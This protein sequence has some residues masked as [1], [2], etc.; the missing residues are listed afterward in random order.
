MRYSHMREVVGLGVQ[1]SGS[2]DGGIVA[3]PNALSGTVG[4]GGF[5]GN[6]ASSP[7]SID[8]IALA[9]SDF[10]YP[11]PVGDISDGERRGAVILHDPTGPL[12]PTIDRGIADASAVL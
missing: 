9:C 3:G 5:R 10:C 6:I 2:G 7:G 1:P 4:V 11:C 8:K 12:Y